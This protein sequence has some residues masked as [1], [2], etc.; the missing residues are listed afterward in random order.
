MTMESYTVNS[1]PSIPNVPAE[2]VAYPHWVC[3][4]WEEDR[5]TGKWKKVPVD[6]RTGKRAKPTD[7]ATWATLMEAMTALLEKGGYDGLG[8][9]LSRDDPYTV[10][11]LDECEELLRSS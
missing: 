4:R 8:F 10:I 3:W 5:R 9:V 6:P 2:L 1:V 7:T 11:D